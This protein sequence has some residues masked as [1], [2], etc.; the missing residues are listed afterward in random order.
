MIEPYIRPFY[1]TLLGN[2]LARIMGKVLS[3]NAV[4]LMGIGVGVMIVPALYY[5]CSVLSLI[6]LGLS[7]ILDTLDGTVARLFHKTSHFGSVLDIVGDRI[8]EF[9]IVLGLFLVDPEHRA[10]ECLVMLGSIMICVTSFLVVGIFSENT[11]HKGFHYSPGLIERSEAFIFFGIM[12]LIPAYFHLLALFF[13]FLV[14]L[15]AVMRTIEFRR[16]MQI[17]DE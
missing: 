6:L 16:I 13:T 9:G 7:G 15:T 10:F 14:F 17:Y 3:P 11:S 8:V 2:P 4:T 5:Q 1:Q 12:I